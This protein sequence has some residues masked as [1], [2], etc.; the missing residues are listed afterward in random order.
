RLPNYRE[1]PSQ[2]DYFTDPDSMATRAGSEARKHSGYAAMRSSMKQRAQ[3]AA[4]DIE[5]VIARSDLIAKDPLSY[6]SGMTVTGSEGR[7]VP[8]PP[9]PGTAGRY[10][11][12]CN[13]GY[14]AEVVTQS[15]PV[16]LDTRLELQTTYAYSCLEGSTV[17]PASP[18]A[19]SNY[20]DAKCTVVQSFQIPCY[21]PGFGYSAACQ[22][23][24]RVDMLSCRETVPGVKPY[25]TETQKVVNTR[26]NTS[27]CATLE[28]TPQ[29]QL[30]AETCSA[31][32][33]LTRTI[34][35]IP[36]TQPCW[37]WARSYSC[38]NFT[39]SEDCSQLE[40]TPGCSLIREDCLAGEPCRTWERVYD[41]PLPDVPVS[42]NQFI[43]DGDIYC[44]DG[45]CES[46]ERTPNSE[47]G[48]A[49]VALKAMD[50]ARKEFD[51]A[52]LRLFSGTRNTCSSK[53]FGVLNCCKGRGF[54]LLPGVNLLLALGCSREE[55]LLHERDAKGLCTYVGSYCSKS[56]LGTCLT[57]RKAYCCFESKLTRILQ[58]QG[59]R[60]LG[61]A[62]N[63]PKR[64][65]CQ[66]FTIA[67]FA[68][69]DLSRMDFSEVYAEFTGAARLPD[70]LEAVTDIQQ[71]IEDYYARSGQ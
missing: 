29:C 4:Q 17:D 38:K 46:I 15:C 58:E 35:G 41:C 48:D 33:P 45:S 5:A 40:T 66:G 18:Y 22:G 54:P 43:C 21:L 11:V 13:S 23:E 39:D 10:Q 61:K 55:V 53:V 34:D 70:E 52:S 25:S 68:R 56:F 20:A 26:R 67:E 3:F 6:T 28:N 24:L 50:Q 16:T 44:I 47:F 14:T 32:D 63:K 27:Q 7:C 69:L 57:K 2:S 9:A 71:K 60:Q 19:C 49:L 37:A 1:N 65:Q 64:E 36:V 8:L 59:R 30:E 12:T 31:S 51:P 62:W 42:Q